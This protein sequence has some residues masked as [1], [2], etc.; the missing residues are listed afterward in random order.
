MKTAEPVVQA[1]VRTMGMAAEGASTSSDVEWVV[2][3]VVRY[4][5]VVAEWWAEMVRYAVVDDSQS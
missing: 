2:T 3:R 4:P 5:V 1:W